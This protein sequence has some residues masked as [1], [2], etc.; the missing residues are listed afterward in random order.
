MAGDLCECGPGHEQPVPGQIDP[1]RRDVEPG[2]IGEPAVP[3]H[4]VVGVLQI[5]SEVM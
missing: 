5:P 1:V 4:L 2:C 3:G